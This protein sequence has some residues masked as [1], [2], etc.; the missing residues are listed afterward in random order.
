LLQGVRVLEFGQ[1]VAG[2]L[3]GM[4]LA[5]LGAEVVRVERPRRA[6]RRHPSWYTYNRNK[7]VVSLD[8]A[9]ET[10]R[11]EA[12]RLLAGADVVIDGL[13]RGDLARYGIDAE[14]ARARRP[15]LVYCEITGFA[16]ET[17]VQAYPWEGI[18]SAAAGFFMPNL[19]NGWERSPSFSS[20]PVAT[21]FAGLLAANAIA[22]ALVCR[23]RSGWGQ[24]IEVPLHSALFYAIGFRLLRT[25]WT[26]DSTLP[27]RPN[28]YNPLVNVYQCSDGRWV[29]LH[30][31]R[32]RFVRAFLEELG[33]QS[34]REEGL[35]DRRR[36]AA[37]PG[38]RAEIKSRLQRLFATQAAE[39]WEER[40]SHAGVSCAVCRSAAE[41]LRHPHAV[42]AGLSVDVATERGP[43]RQ[44]G[45]IL[46]SHAATERP[47]APRLC[48]SR[49]ID[50]QPRA[51]PQ[52]GPKPSAALEGVL[53]LDLGQVLAGPTAG[54]ILA[55][56]GADVIKVDPPDLALNDAFWLDTNRGKRSLLL[57]LKTPAGREVFG[58]LVRDADVLIENFRI[59]V[60]GRLGIDY[61]TLKRRN[62]RLVYASLNCYG[63]AGPFAGR[64]GWEQLAQAVTGIQARNG[65][66]GR[67]PRL[68][69]FAILDYA[70]GLAASLG[71]L[72]ALYERE[73]TTRGRR[74]TT[75]LVASAGILQAPLMS[76]YSGGRRR[77][78]EGPDARGLSPLSRIYATADGWV[79][80]HC[81]L[82]EASRLSDVPELRH[83]A[84]PLAS[85]KR[86][87]DSGL[88]HGLEE[89]FLSRPSAYWESVLNRGRVAVMALG[90]SWDLFAKPGIRRAGL[91]ETHHD[92]AW[93]KV[94]HVGIPHRLS[95]T[96]AVSGAR[97][98]LPGSDTRKVLLARG[99][100]ARAYERLRRSG[101]ARTSLSAVG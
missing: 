15:D 94:E 55:E 17:G 66:R 91:I 96:P 10:G 42:Q 101:A 99:V 56:F 83:L 21:T 70:T 76:G 33:L 95:L 4:L 86:R 87:A 20:L 79:Y 62:G 38:L 47:L 19:P 27:D 18:V 65:G 73:S 85:C 81:P 54:R 60:T 16:P 92:P 51:V 46:D 77:E 24:R 1:Q 2:P 40:L 30:V 93:G 6:R 14:A 84:G 100:S 41:W 13:K 74:V 22:A 59:G 43:L 5:D 32:P 78:F 90:R 72:A 23:R 68:A 58:T 7:S 34:W 37:D 45:P 28:R 67:R 89:A 75:S 3:T 71:V 97:V 39:Y 12:L 52:R 80:L 64:P 35:L 63:Y 9:S 61:E 82:T 98:P 69:R 57:D 29:Q 88:E 48:D 26:A 36:L 49:D 53:A 11:S 25:N 44:P 50:W 8:L 31:T